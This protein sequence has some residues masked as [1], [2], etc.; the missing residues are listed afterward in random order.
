MKKFNKTY[1]TKNAKRA[2]IGLLAGAVAACGIDGAHVEGAVS[3]CKNHGGVTEMLYDKSTSRVRCLDGSL[4][5]GVGG[6]SPLTFE[7][8]N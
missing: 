8:V 4:F 7:A 5:E 1:K 6:A 3:A 2:A